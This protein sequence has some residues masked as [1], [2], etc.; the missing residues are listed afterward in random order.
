MPVAARTQSE[1]T[2]V[3]LIFSGL[4]RLGPD[5]TYEPDLA[6]SW[7]TDAKGKTWTFRIRDDAT[8]QDGEP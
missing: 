7:T 8:W 6:E 3:G 4:V 2:L 5:N 1:R